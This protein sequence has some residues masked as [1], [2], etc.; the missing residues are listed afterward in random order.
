M[1]RLLILLAAV[2]IA[3]SIFI[4]SSQAYKP[5]PAVNSSENAAAITPSDGANL[6]Q[7]TMA[8]Y[9]GG[10]GDVKVDMVGSGTGIVFKA[11]PVG[12]VLPV[13]AIKV[14]STGTTATNLV[15]IY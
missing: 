3:G 13:Q 14:Y 11:V 6:S 15:A 2:A 9:V 10:A 12:T 4:P 7:Q 1:K 5:Q 8:I